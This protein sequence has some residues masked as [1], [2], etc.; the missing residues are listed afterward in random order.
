M[1]VTPG[2]TYVAS[3]FA[4]NGHYSA[5]PSF[6]YVP[7]PFGSNTLDSPPLHALKANGTT[8]NGIYDY[9][10]RARSRRPRYNA[11]NYW[12]DV[13]FSPSTPPGDGDERHRDGRHRLGER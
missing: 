4:P 8:A 13:I 1:P 2:T 12:V 9:G 10:A 3:Y 7:A 5:T 6:F 11:T